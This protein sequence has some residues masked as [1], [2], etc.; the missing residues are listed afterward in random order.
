LK[1][2]V[3][4]DRNIP[5]SVHTLIGKQ[6][7]VPV[8][9]S[10]K[11]TNENYRQTDTRVSFLFYCLKTTKT[12]SNNEKYKKSYKISL[13]FESL[14][15]IVRCCVNREKEKNE[16]TDEVCPECVFIVLRRHPSRE[17]CSHLSRTVLVVVGER[18]IGS[19]HRHG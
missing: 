16:R 15:L 3:C 6:L 7:P 1:K 14:Q 2:N 19:F 13:S 9:E 17:R 5:N 11:I 18:T 8:R 4:R 12:K 10:L